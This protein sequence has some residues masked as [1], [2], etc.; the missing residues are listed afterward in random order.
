MPRFELTIDELVLHGF[1]HGDRHAIAA[2]VEAELGRLLSAPGG[3]PVPAR[4]RDV[5]AVVSRAE[6]RADAAPAMA[7]ADI[8]AAVHRSVTKEVR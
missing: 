3:T 6:I 7:G 4:N 8:A 1:A 5:A 2:A